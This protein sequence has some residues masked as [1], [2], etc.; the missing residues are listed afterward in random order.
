M[1]SVLDVTYKRP[2]KASSSFSASLL[3]SSIQTEGVLAHGKLSY[4]AG[5]R[6]KT[7]KYVLNSLETTGEY[8]PTFMDFQTLIAYQFS[9]KF[10][11]SYLSNYSSN[12]FD[13]IPKDQR[14]SFGTLS[15]MLELYIAF[16][17]HERDEYSTWTNALS[18]SYSPS[19]NTQLKFIASAYQSEEKERF[20]ILGR[21]SLNSLSRLDGQS[22]NDSSLALGIGAFLNHAR[23]SLNAKVYNFQHKGSLR[24][25][26]GV[27]QWG[28]QLQ[29]EVISSMT[30]EWKLIDSAEYSL[31]NRSDGIN[32][33]YSYNGSFDLATTR[34]SAFAQHSLPFTINESNCTLILG[35][36]LA[37]SNQNKEWLLSPRL[38]FSFKPNWENDWL[39]R[40]SAGIYYQAPFYKEFQFLDRSAY[41]DV[42][43]NKSFHYIV[44]GD[45]YFKAWG[46]PFKLICEAYYKQMDIIPYRIENTRVKYMADRRAMAYARGLDFKLNGE[47]VKGAESWFSLSLMQS[48]QK[49]DGSNVEEPLPTDQLIN[50]GLF[51]QD[52]FP[53]NDSYKVNLML[54][55]GSPLPFGPPDEYGLNSS[56]RMPSYNRADI[57]FTK[58]FISPRRPAS[59]AYWKMFKELS[60]TGEIFNL[61]GI[62][63]TVSYLWLTVVPPANSS[64]KPSYHQLAVPNRLTARR[65]NLKLVARF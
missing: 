38:G 56:F 6:Y 2:T 53:G 10:T 51:F 43:S 62:E 18:F 33:S 22:T 3:G 7:S 42:R 47:F 16:N 11:V 19:D 12:V 63:N 52:Y 65:L 58:E 29:R 49:L 30:N 45:Y 8:S 64:E 54:L 57:G 14:T 21:Y 50:A 39:F 13:F 59:R 35:A 24:T 20:D 48:R 41:S 25:G 5:Y 27:L 60:L 15:S 40:A 4:N 31:P 17:G 28:A 61:F 9:P 46:R 36:R 32:L 55:Y 37:H 44:G 1:S 34:Y 26:N 23:N